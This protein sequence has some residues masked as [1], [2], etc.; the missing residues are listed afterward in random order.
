MQPIG[1]F[2]RKLTPAE[3]NYQI[4]DKEFLAIR[5]GLETWRYLLLDTATPVNIQCDHK[6]L[7]YFM[8]S[9]RLNR[10]QARY[11]D[12]LAD[13]NIQIIYT[14]GDSMVVADPL[15]R[16]T[17]HESCNQ[18]I[19]AELN[20]AVL[21]PPALFR[22]IKTREMMKKRIVG[23]LSQEL[24]SPAQ[25]ASFISFTTY[26]SGLRIKLKRR[27]KLCLHSVTAVES[28]VDLDLLADPSKTSKSDWPL[29][30]VEFLTTGQIPSQLPALFKKLVRLQKSRFVLR[31][32]ALYRKVVVDRSPAA[33]PYIVP[34]GRV[35]KL[36]E[37]HE[38]F[39]H[40]STPS[41]LKSLQ[42]RCWW[43]QMQRD[44]DDFVKQC[45]KCQL[46]RVGSKQK[47]HPMHPLAP[48][49]IPFHR[50]G[51]DFIQDLPQNTEG[52]TQIIT[53]MDYSTRW[54]IAKPVKDR[55]SKT[56]AEFL[57]QE[58]MMKF[59]APSEIITDRAS[60]FMSKVMQDY[61][62]CQRFHHYPSTPY[63][64]NTNGLVERVHS[65]LGSIITK[66]VEG[67]PSKW[68]QFVAPAAFA[69]NCR[70]HTVTGF[71]PFQL[72]Y[73]FSPRLPG[74]IDPPFVF[75][76][77][78][79]DEQ[80]LYT[81]KELLQMG[82]RRAAALFKSQR[83]AELMKRK[84]DSDPKVVDETYP[85]GA[86]VKVFNHARTKFK[87]KWNGPFI[88]D[89]LGPNNSYYLMAPNGLELKSPINQNH[90]SPWISQLELEESNTNSDEEVAEHGDQ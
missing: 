39:G 61:A 67:M 33:V 76:L 38:V 31:R 6:N 9:Q 32:G 42:V 26:T 40:L 10:R 36:K 49:G 59:G 24:H 27:E 89:R 52:F 48:P 2:S 22:E 72:V 73:G 70:T 45:P 20:Q 1:F 11:L 4:Y 30:M 74:D 75:D 66:M 43:P 65:V 12:F 54:V 19:S 80:E 82:Q 55:T 84:H 18:K 16:N 69:L 57:F 81:R 56:V 21:L 23:V 51:L 86:Y 62:D 44:L 87:D 35:A 13:Y 63:H 64:P 8:T 90:I 17:G 15:S 83:Q 58:V 14:K 78:N 37:L 53:C 50:W 25:S 7:S 79:T 60:C 41:I 88:I 28:A 29:F 46:N 85:V 34:S 3:L 5:E 71:S 77:K 47:S 68:P